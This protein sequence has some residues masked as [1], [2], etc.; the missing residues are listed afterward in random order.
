MNANRLNFDLPTLHRHA[1]G[2]DRLF[3]ELGRNFVSRSDNNYHYPPYNIVKRDE[4]HYT[5]DIAVAGF[6]QDELQVEFKENI[7]TVTGRQVA[8]DNATEQEYLHRGISSRSFTR[9]FTLA[10]NV[11]VRQATVTNGILSIE[12]EHVIPEE[13]RAKRIQI[14]YKG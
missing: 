11:E 7:L 14:E 1:I 8:E 6:S 10:D 5:V 12:L 2:F 4:S 3:D 13:K 9:N